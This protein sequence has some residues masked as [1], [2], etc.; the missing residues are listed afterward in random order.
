MSVEGKQHADVVAAIKAGGDETKLL[1]VG[2]LAD[3]F[4]KKCRVVPSEAHL[5]GGSG[6]TPGVG[7]GV[8]PCAGTVGLVG[9]F[10]PSP[11][12]VCGCG[13]RA[14]QGLWLCGLRFEQGLWLRERTEGMRVSFTLLQP[15]LGL[16][17]PP[18]PGCWQDVD[19]PGCPG[20]VVPTGTDVHSPGVSLSPPDIMSSLQVLCQNPWPMVM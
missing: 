18:C 4:F 16:G 17:P 12:L 14:G 3:E 5:A 6:A 19:L 11:R 10:L 15:W 9:T 13:V 20:A 2:V 1:V 7:H 8:S